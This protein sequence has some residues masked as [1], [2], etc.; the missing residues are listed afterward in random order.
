MSSNAKGGKGK[1]KGKGKG[2]G[3]SAKGKKGNNQPVGGGVRQN[4]KKFEFA[5][6]SKFATTATTL[7]YDIVSD[8]ECTKG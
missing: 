4:S 2:A 3:S 7:Q 1:A 6:A 5:N 8:A